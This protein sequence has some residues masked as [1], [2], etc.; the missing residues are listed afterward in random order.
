MNTLTD[1]TMISWTIA[2]T[3]YAIDFML[4]L[5]LL[6]YIPKNRRP[7]AA[8]AWLL[9]IFALPILGTVLFFLIGNTK[10]SRLKQKKQT[11]IVALIRNYTERLEQQ[12][13]IAKLSPELTS[14]ANLIRSLTGFAPT[15]GNSVDIING[16]Q[17][18]IDDMISAVNHAEQYVYVEFFALVLDQT[19]EPFF[20]ALRQAKDRGVDV[21]VLYDL[22]GSRKYPN[23]KQMKLRLD[24][25]VTG[26][27]TLHP[28]SL[29][30]SKYNRP[31][32]RN[33]RKILVIDNTDAFIGSLNMVHETYHRKDDISYIELVAHFR[34]PVVNEAA[35]VF[36]GDW[37]MET[38]EVLSHFTE[39][40][41]I[42]Q[43]ANV[44][45]QI[46]PS[47]PAY[48]YENN[49]KLFVATILGAKKSVS[50][51]N[52]YLVPDDSF[53]NA[54]VTAALGGV[55]VSILNSE[56]MDQ[57]MVGHAQR[58]YYE[59]LLKAG[60]RIYLYKK[61]QLV[62]EKF[63]TIDDEIA[64]VGSS[65][66]DIRSFALNDEC[67]VVSYDS[68]TAEVLRQ[69]HELLKLHSD[70][71]DLATWQKRSIWKSFLDS[72]ARLTSALQ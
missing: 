55:E 58:S 40:P 5:W 27:S 46:L 65:N 31:D 52:P 41:L 25:D 64:L 72:I 6:F 37:H 13:L 29:R 39:H 68:K 21:Y 28:L 44:S 63:I 66:F 20:D 59:E 49:L 2:G 7:T 60:V 9:L 23:Y 43:P 14:Y 50:I 4:R 57:W 17:E 26:W 45:M 32:L 62:H 33:H 69:R 48:P 22:F 1:T 53:L 15:H 16:Y 30:P 67:T 70:E 51:T 61:P 8:N 47:G 34:G 10:L 18:I 54:L 24:S 71:I 11:T 36:A 38:D 12:N 19:T 3:I 42:T 35:I 56:A